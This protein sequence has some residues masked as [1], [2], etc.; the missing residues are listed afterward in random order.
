MAGRVSA[1]P[2]VTS[3]LGAVARTLYLGADQLSLVQGTGVVGAHVLDGVELA[4]HVAERHPMALQLV[5]AHFAGRHV[6]GF[7]YLVNSAIR[8]RHTPRSRARSCL[9]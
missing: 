7:G 9:Q 1:F 8:L 3:E 6:T 4:F 5:D 2:V